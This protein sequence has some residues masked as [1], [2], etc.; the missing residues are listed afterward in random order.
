MEAAAYSSV[1][2]W[3]LMITM[4]MMSMATSTGTLT[5]GMNMAREME[6]LISRVNELVGVWLLFLL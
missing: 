4:T 5:K 3:T 2:F 6:R 1:G